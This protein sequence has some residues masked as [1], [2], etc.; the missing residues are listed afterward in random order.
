MP[1][2]GLKH[3]VLWIMWKYSK[4]SMLT[5]EQWKNQETEIR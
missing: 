5:E 2:L 1:G 3:I 4:Y